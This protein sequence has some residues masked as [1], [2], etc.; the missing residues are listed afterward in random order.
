[1]T[2]SRPRRLVYKVEGPETGLVGPSKITS[3][4]HR[5]LHRVAPLLD[6][7]IFAR[8]KQKIQYLHRLGRGT[9]NVAR[10]K[11]RRRVVMRLYLRCG[12]RL[13]QMMTG[14]LHPCSGQC[15]ALEVLQEPLLQFH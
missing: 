13:R 1:M 3:P 4:K 14:T 2:A 6:W 11:S 9:Q 10:V 7:A 12:R 15:N 5:K 8:T